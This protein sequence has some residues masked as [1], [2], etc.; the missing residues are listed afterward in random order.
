VSICIS[1]GARRISA[2]DQRFGNWSSAC[3]KPPDE[4]YSSA[5]KFETMQLSGA[6]S[7]AGPTPPILRATTG[8]ALKQ[9]HDGEGRRRRDAYAIGRATGGGSKQIT[10]ADRVR[11]LGPLLVLP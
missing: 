7:G 1:L 4:N 3:A 11:R 8:D 2:V 6:T 10:D 9:R 5:C